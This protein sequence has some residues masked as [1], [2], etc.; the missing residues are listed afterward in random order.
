MVISAYLK[1]QFVVPPQRDIVLL[2]QVVVEKT[3]VVLIQSSAAM[4]F[5]LHQMSFAAQQIQVNPVRKGRH[6]VLMG[7]ATLVSVAMVSVVLLDLSV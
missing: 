4:V 6:V 2:A 1:M 3:I 5:V 7:V